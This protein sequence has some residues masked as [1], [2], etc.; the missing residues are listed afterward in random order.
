LLS[1][2]HLFLSFLQL[3]N[4]LW[5]GQVLSAAAGASSVAA[6]ADSMTRAMHA[7]NR[8]LAADPRLLVTMLP[9]RDGITIVQHRPTHMHN[10]KAMQD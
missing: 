3:D 5:K 7:L 6:T 2:V 8:A 9:V 10:D 1:V 4:T